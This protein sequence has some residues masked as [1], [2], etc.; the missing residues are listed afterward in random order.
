MDQDEEKR[1]RVLAWWRY[2]DEFRADSG[3]PARRPWKLPPEARA[4][5]ERLIALLDYDEISECIMRAE[6]LRQLSRFSEAMEILAETDS[7]ETED[8]VARLRSMCE[9]NDARL[10]QLSPDAPA[11]PEATSG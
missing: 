4:N 5:L 8:V 3:R 10:R 11:E 9:G 2:N 6:A 1:L 7:E